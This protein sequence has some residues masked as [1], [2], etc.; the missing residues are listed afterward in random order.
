[1]FVA[2]WWFTR[3]DERLFNTPLRPSQLLPAAGVILL[4]FLLNIEIADYYSTGPEILFR[5]GA[6]VQQDLTYTLGWLVFGGLLLTAGIYLRNRPARLTAVAMI[7]ITAVK[8][9]VYDLREFGGLYR[10]GSLV[11]LAIALLLVAVAL[12]KFVLA[13]PKDAQ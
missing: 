8:C 3:T 10:V 9:F 13:K 4:F 7:A 11:G 5:F 2:A 6:A 12:Q 1:M